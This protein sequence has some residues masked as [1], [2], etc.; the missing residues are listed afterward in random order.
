MP[1]SR[2]TEEVQ[3]GIQGYTLLHNRLI[4][5]NNEWNFLE[6]GPRQRLLIWI[7]IVV[8]VLLM[9]S[10]LFCPDGK[11][12]L[13]SFSLTCC[14]GMLLIRCVGKD[15]PHS[16]FWHP[17]QWYISLGIT[18]VST[19]VMQG[20]LWL[21]PYLDEYWMVVVLFLFFLYLLD[22]NDPTVHPWVVRKFL[23][24]LRNHGEEKDH[25]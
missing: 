3:E 19:A 12:A 10:I 4:Q 25:V 9:I 2:T 24:I 6:R 15:L 7:W 22:L 21:V 8:L 1:F 13:L 17:Q 14:T 5:C 11:W 23:S 20:G 18:I 16:H